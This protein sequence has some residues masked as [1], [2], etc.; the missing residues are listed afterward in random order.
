LATAH[1]EPRSVRT[2]PKQ[3]REPAVQAPSPSAAPRERELSHA[4]ALA[5]ARAGLWTLLLELPDDLR[6]HVLRGGDVASKRARRFQSYERLEV[7]FERLVGFGAGKDCAQ[8]RERI[9]EARRLHRSIARSREQLVLDN[10][11]LVPQVVRQFH[12]G[13]IPVGDLVQE[14]YVGLLQAVDRFDPGR[15][16]RFATYAVW[17]IR[18]SL[19]ETFSQRSRLIRLPDSVR[20]D[21]RLMRRAEAELEVDLGRRPQPREVAA[22]MKVS[23]RKLNKLLNVV[24]EPT[25]LDDLTSREQALSEQPNV[26]DPLERTLESELRGHARQ[27]LGLLDVRELTVIRMR[28]GFDGEMHTLSQIGTVIGLSRERVRQIECAALDKI[29]AW[30]VRRGLGSAR[31]V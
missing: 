31:A 12:T 29:H 27:A 18:R 14:G 28:F 8:L 2:R 22:R 24:P 9:D 16:Y 19:L 4:C 7:A 10:L 17:W 13:P 25:A 11:Y 26:P 3:R 23:P 6:S 5:E 1:L 21:L 30:A 20:E 15:G